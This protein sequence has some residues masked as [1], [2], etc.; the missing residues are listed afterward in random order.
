[1]SRHVVLIINPASAN[2]ATGREWPE[3]VAEAQ[4]LGVRCE[5]RLTEAPGHAT[6]LAR[7]AEI[8]RAHV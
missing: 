3:L 1:M 5:E 7:E 4:R 2:G 8:G 6:E